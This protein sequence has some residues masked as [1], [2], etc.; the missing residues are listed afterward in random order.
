MITF[1]TS[2]PLWA[3]GLILVGLTTLVSMCGPPLV[4]RYIALEKLTSNN[5]VA[6][7]KFATVGV[8]YAVFLAFAIILVWQ[9][10]SDADATVAKEAGAAASI[11]H[12]SK[13]IPEASGAALRSSLGNYLK[14]VVSDEWPA[15]ERGERSKP[16][17]QALE[18]MYAALVTAANGE[19]R[20]S[21][22]A[23]E[24]FH[25][26]DVLTAARRT[27]LLAA[28]GSVPAIVWVVLFG[29][30]TATIAFALFFGTKNLRAQSIM[31]G[32]LSALIFAELLIVVAIDRP[33][34]GTVK[35]EPQALTDVLVD[36]GG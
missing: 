11:Y 4:R 16:A 15:M 34:T 13:G 22:L 26:L 19:Q 20:D 6:G 5:E 17:H 35:V 10:Y 36:E 29:G 28:E 30:A 24:L 14:L 3:S 12:L 27:R 7:F 9:K 21:A 2:Q 33:F 8:L 32:L 31:M 23:S 25:Q 1:L 18:S